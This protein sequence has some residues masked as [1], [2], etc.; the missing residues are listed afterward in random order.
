M[1]V[2]VVNYTAIDDSSAVLYNQTAGANVSGSTGPLNSVSNTQQLSLRTTPV[3]ISLSQ[4]TT[5]RMRVQFDQTQGITA[6]LQV[7]GGA[8][9][10]AAVMSAYRLG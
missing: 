4:S 7:A 9:G 10:Y 3:Q 6:Q 5:F 1:G 8:G 2:I